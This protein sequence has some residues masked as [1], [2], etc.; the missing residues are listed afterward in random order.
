MKRILALV[1]VLTLLL[2]G[3]ATKPP[4]IGTIPSTTT[5]GTAVPQEPE[6]DPLPDNTLS[7]ALVNNDR[8][9][10]KIGE[11]WGFIDINGEVIIEPLL[12][13][14]SKFNAGLLPVNDNGLWGYMN[15]DGDWEIQ[16]KFVIAMPF[17]EGFATVGLLDETLTH[18]VYSIINHTGRTITQFRDGCGR[19]WPFKKGVAVVGWSNQK[20]AIVDRTGS[21]VFD[22]QF[23]QFQGD[24]S[25]YQI[26]FDG[27]IGVKSDGK[28]G[29]L[30]SA[31]KWIIEAQFEG[32]EHFRNRLCTVKKDGKWGVIDTTGKFVIEPQYD[33]YVIFEDGLASVKIGEKYGY[34]N[35]KGETVIQPRFI[36][37]RDFYQGVAQ[38]LTDDGWG[39]IDKKGNWILE[40]G[41]SDMGLFAQG[42]AP[43]CVDG[44]N[45]G[46]IDTTGK[47]VIAADYRCTTMFYEDGYAAVMTQEGKWTVIDDAGDRIFDKT[48]DGVGN[49]YGTIDENGR[50]SQA[51]T[52]R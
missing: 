21:M 15:P 37:A 22:T 39:L 17:S 50:L 6:P 28:W 27:L 5:G 16:P 7:D 20:Y 42:L 30:D 3:C 9:C 38:V 1:L 46:Y 10:V 48:F 25:T 34:I 36:V 19:G 31:G 33:W 44:T 43:V 8:I 26:I 14:P 49:Y 52:G 23:E 18:P 29:F 47:L 40:P 45:W 32:V 2:C 11:Q 41:Y 51:T 12:K 13:N 24:E 35:T 4:S